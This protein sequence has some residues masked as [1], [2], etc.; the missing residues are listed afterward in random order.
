M[1]KKQ[2]EK[3]L[4]ELKVS[5]AT[6]SKLLKNTWRERLAVEKALRLKIAESKLKKGE[7]P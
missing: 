5:T 7:K 2:L 3:R 6:I 4:K 1:N